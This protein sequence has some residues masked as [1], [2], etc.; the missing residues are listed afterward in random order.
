MLYVD[1]IVSSVYPKYI[2]ISLV[3]GMYKS[4]VLDIEAFVC[5]LFSLLLNFTNI[6]CQ[7]YCPSLHQH[8][9]S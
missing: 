1:D 2:S 8:M 9:V 6:F 3:V 4:I 7:T 5:P